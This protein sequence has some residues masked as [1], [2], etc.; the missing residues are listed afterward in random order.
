MP[1]KATPKSS[2]A[3]RDTREAIIDALMRLAALREWSQIGVDD[4]A[5]EAGVTLA[6]FRALFPS[7]GAILAAFARRTDIAVL[8]QDSNDLADE[9]ARE[10]LFDV[11]MRRIDALTPHKAALRRIASAVRLDPA[12]MLA[13]NGVALN[14]QRFMLAYAGISTDDDLGPLKLQGAVL[15]F[16]RTLDVW[17]D[18]DDPGLARTMARLDEELNRGERVMRV[19]DDVHRFTAPFRAALRSVCE[20][21]ERRRKRADADNRQ[22][23]DEPEGYAASI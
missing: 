16:A 21:G 10:R 15:A 9:P 17:F 4:I 11:M 12:T 1:A 19:A 8:A 3:P 6:E 13:L 7:K 20:G 18:D 2:D 5:G 22:S 14:S 23:A